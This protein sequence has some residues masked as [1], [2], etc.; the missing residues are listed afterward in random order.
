M[1]NLKLKC[2]QKEAGELLD[3]AHV[4]N[5]R[6]EIA[7]LRLMLQEQLNQCQDSHDLV[8]RS[9]PVADLILKIEKLV[10][11]CHRLEVQTNQV[12]D[13]QS[14]MNLTD[15]LVHLLPEYVPADRLD[16]LAATIVE[17][18]ADPDAVRPVEKPTTT[19]ATTAADL[20]LLDEPDGQ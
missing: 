18:F 13:R 19:A 2:W 14:L 20:S 9:G 6:D 7:I 1:Y 5:L 16:A 11:S 4:K 12:L 10:Q 3:S 8:L 17:L 15:R